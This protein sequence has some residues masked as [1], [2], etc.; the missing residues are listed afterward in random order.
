MLAAA[1]EEIVR[2]EQEDNFVL[3]CSNSNSACDELFRRL[4]QVLDKN[5]ILRLYTPSYDPQKVNAE[6]LKLSNWDSR[7]KSFT[8]PGLTFLYEFRVL[9]C[10][11]AVS[12]CL[13]KANKHPLFKSDHFSHIIIDESCCTHE[14]MSLIPI[15]G[16]CYIYIW[17]I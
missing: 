4:Y 8:M 11:L 13:T 2:D 1:V 3:I 14:T 17:L 7:S 16:T 6:I 9:V 15:A 10:T 12:S 5:E